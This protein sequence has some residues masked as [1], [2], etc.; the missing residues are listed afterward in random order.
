MRTPTNKNLFRY[1]K[2]ILINQ[3]KI[4]FSDIANINKKIS[5]SGLTRLFAEN[6]Q[7]QILY[8]NF[9]K[10]AVSILGGYFILDD[11]I[12]EKPYSQVNSF[13]RF[14]FS[15]K[16]NKTVKGI[17]VVVLLL[18]IGFIRIPLG[19]RIYDKKKTKIQLAL[20]LFSEARNKYG[21]RRIVVLFDSWYCAGK[22]LKRIKD[23]GWHY[24]CRIKRNRKI[25]GIPVKYYFQSPYGIKEGKLSGMKIKIVRNG[26]YYLITDMLSLTKYEIMIWYKKRTKIEQFFK[27][28]K[29]YFKVK[30]CQC[31]RRQTYENHLIMANISY[32]FVELKRQKYHISIYKAKRRFRFKQYMPYVNLL[33]S[34]L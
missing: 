2:E 1:I 15:H 32:C 12:L 3:G 20:N 31:K 19:F 30:D 6:N 10:K 8:W 13:I 21:F 28:W 22:I 5:Y 27:E 29:T 26:K 16:E 17:Q 7:W 4:N 33:N 11:T 23:Y 14:V 24:V 25:Q 34:L 18:V 9:I